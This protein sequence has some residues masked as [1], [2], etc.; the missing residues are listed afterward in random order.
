MLNIIQA[1]LFKIRKGKAFYGVMMGLLAIVILIGGVLKVIGSPAFQVQMSTFEESLS[2]EDKQ[3][4]S[5]GQEIVPANG[6]EFLRMAFQEMGSAFILFLLPF[7]ITV[8]GADYSSGTYRNLL[9]YHS[10]RA[11]IYAAKTITS[12]IL[13][14]VMLVGF[15]IFGAVIGGI[16]FGFGGFT[17]AVFMEIIK[18]SVLLL[19]V[20]GAVIALG[21]CIMA[22]V[23]KTSYT[24]SIF[25]VGALVWS[26]ILQ[27]LAMLVP[28]WEW[29]LQ[30]DLMSA[31]K[32]IGQYA[33]NADV[34]I[35]I[36]MVFSVI[37]L[38]GSYVIGSLKYSRT[39][40]DFN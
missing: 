29:I 20:L 3:E 1:D 19:P 28:R 22:F 14:V 6:G 15:T 11:E 8:F 38:V 4:L 34:S 16:L 37:L 33:A 17:A 21:Y 32:M 23:K 10:K 5:D 27:V 35:M 31:V 39:D 40:F 13:T 12:L 30:L 25:L 18:T 36:P 26:L 2:E 7:I 9:S 24:I